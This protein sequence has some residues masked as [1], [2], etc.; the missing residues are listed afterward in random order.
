MTS[1]IRRVLLKGPTGPGTLR[2]MTD[3]QGIISRPQ[4]TSF[5]SRAAQRT[6]F[7]LRRPSEREGGVCC[8]PLGPRRDA[9]RY[10]GTSLYSSSLNGGPANLRTPSQVDTTKRSQ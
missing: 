3:L 7:R 10:S 6:R 2:R 4:T 8:Q 5:V 1:R 9:R